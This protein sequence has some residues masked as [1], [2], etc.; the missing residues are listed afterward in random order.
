MKETH[1][2]IRHFPES[3]L[4][5]FRWQV[6]T[7]E[8]KCEVYADNENERPDGTE[9]GEGYTPIWCVYGFGATLVEALF[10]AASR[11]TEEINKPET[12]NEH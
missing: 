6:G 7:F 5:G 12:T 4:E 2:R 11:I 3:R 9:S 1:I 10:R 8:F